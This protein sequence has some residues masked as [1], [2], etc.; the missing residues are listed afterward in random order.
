MWKTLSKPKDMFIFYFQ[1]NYYILTFSQEGRGSEEATP[2]GT[3]RELNWYGAH[4]FHFY[5]VKY[6][7]EKV[8]DC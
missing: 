6:K 3:G 8:L 5:K 4:I 7:K 1:G 2:V